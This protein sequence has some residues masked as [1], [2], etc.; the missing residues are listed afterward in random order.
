M[1]ILHEEPGFNTEI[2]RKQRDRLREAIKAVTSG[3]EGDANLYTMHTAA[4]NAAPHH[5][6]CICGF[7][8]AMEA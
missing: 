8:F 1:S 6:S 7:D 4:Y 2:L 5:D 3:S